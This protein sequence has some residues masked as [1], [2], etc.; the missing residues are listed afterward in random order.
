MKKL[1]RKINNK[2]LT[3]VTVAQLLLNPKKPIT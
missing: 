2:P 1:I 3:R